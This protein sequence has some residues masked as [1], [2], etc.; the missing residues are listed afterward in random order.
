M[1]SSITQRSTL[2]LPHH[3]RELHSNIEPSQERKGLAAD[4]PWDVR[5]FLEQATS[6]LT[7][8]PYTRLTGSYARHTA[9]HG[10]KDVDFVVFVGSDD[11]ERPDPVAVLDALYATLKALPDFLEMEGSAQILRKQRRSVHV[12]FPE[13]DFHLDVVP[14]WM[15]GGLDAPLMVPD[16]DWS[17]WVTTDPL[18]YGRALSE[19]NSDTGEKAV[20][21]IKLL[22]HWRTVQMDR[23]RPKNF[24][25]EVLVYHHLKDG[26]IEVIGKSSAELF[27]D[28]LCAIRDDFQAYLD[29]ETVPAIWDP[30]L[31]TNN[32]AFNWEFDPFR[33]FMTRL[34]ESIGWAQRA[35]AKSRDELD[36]AI[37]LWQKVFGTEYFIDSP[38]LRKL[39]QTEWLGASP[40]LFVGSDGKVMDR[41]PDNQPVVVSRP[42]RFYGDPR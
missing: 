15:D 42:H 4:L 39:Q 28:L 19:L 23:K 35:L 36:E 22:K 29:A 2:T 9:I 8:N 11:G 20:P 41:R 14:V 34:A 1:A 32:I 33:S 27:T 12:A 38:D 30:M 25:L 10:I 18:G 24:W 5:E 40:A 6:L 31:P 3:F 37:V 7:V 17:R 13:P 16:K 21:L 26:T